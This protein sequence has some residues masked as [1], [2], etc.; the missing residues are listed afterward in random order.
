MPS[1]WLKSSQF[2][3]RTSKSYSFLPYIG[4]WCHQVHYQGKVYQH[5]FFKYVEFWKMGMCKDETY[6]RKFGSYVAYGENILELLLNLLP[7]QNSTLLEGFWSSNNWRSNHMWSAISTIVDADLKDSIIAPYCDPKNMRPSLKTTVDTPF[8]DSIL[9]NF[10]LVKPTNLELYH[11][12]MGRVESEVVKDKQFENF[13]YLHI[14]WWV[15]V[16][17]GTRNDRK[18][19][20]DC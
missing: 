15:L 12:W 18:L 5:Q 8:W 11:V 16:K 17:K 4:E 6:A 13:R 1:G 9:D 7:H 2:A 14:Q 19:Y 20:H 3:L 10:V